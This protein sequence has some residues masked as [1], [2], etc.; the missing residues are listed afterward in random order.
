MWPS[1]SSGFHACRQSALDVQIC[2]CSTIRFPDRWRALTLPKTGS[3]RSCLVLP[4]TSRPEGSRSTPRLEGRVASGEDSTRNCSSR[5]WF[6]SRKHFPKEQGLSDSRSWSSCSGGDARWVPDWP[7][8]HRWQAWRFVCARL[9][10]D[11]GRCET[12][13]RKNGSHI[14]NLCETTA[15]FCFMPRS[16]FILWKNN[17]HSFIY[18]VS[19]FRRGCALKKGMLNVTDIRSHIAVLTR[20]KKWQ[21]LS[22]GGGLFE[23]P[24]L[25]P[26]W[27]IWIR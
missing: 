11:L 12:F 8:G 23:D 20:T 21:G 3:W 5:P 10:I 7:S 24:L 15:F 16:Y 6:V 17:R 9:Q 22:E 4:V 1:C 26:A 25:S 14:Y 27:R 2:C 19:L 18:A 13:S